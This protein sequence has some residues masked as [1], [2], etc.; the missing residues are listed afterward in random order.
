MQAVQKRHDSYFYIF[1]EKLLQINSKISMYVHYSLSSISFPVS[2]GRCSHF[3]AHTKVEKK[4]TFVHR[5]QYTSHD[6]SKNN[7]PV[8]CHFLHIKLNNQRSPLHECYV[9]MYIYV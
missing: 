6:G 2:W 9:C 3:L 5:H 4:K 1:L 7:V 8:A